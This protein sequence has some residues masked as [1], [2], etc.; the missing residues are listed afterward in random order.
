[1]TETKVAGL[2]WSVFP[3]PTQPTFPLDASPR[4]TPAHLKQVHIMGPA[5][6][7]FDSANSCRGPVAR[8]SRLGCAGAVCHPREGQAVSQ[9]SRAPHRRR[10]EEK[11]QHHDGVQ[12]IALIIDDYVE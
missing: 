8:S 3:R 12:M 11:A 1:M 10:E 7:S 2:G 6:S 5:T 9:R 4:V